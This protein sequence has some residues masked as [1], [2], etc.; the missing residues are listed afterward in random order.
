MLKFIN[1]LPCDWLISN[2]C[3]QEQVYL[4]KWPVSVHVHIHTHSVITCNW[5]LL[6]IWLL[7]HLLWKSTI[8]A[9][10]AQAVNSNQYA[11]PT[12][13]PTIISL[14]LYARCLWRLCLYCNH[15]HTHVLLSEFMV[16]TKHCWIAKPFVT[17]LWYLCSCSIDL[18]DLGFSIQVYYDLQ[19]FGGI[20]LNVLSIKSLNCISS[21]TGHTFSFFIH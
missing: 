11:S 4:I 16:I 7:P 2:L 3:Y 13:S 18:H 20:M 17:E 14:C 15:I 19:F 6:E 5:C 1:L 8:L 10:F 21:S 12:V 9:I